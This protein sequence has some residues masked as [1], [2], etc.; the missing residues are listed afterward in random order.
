MDKE[1]VETNW[2]TLEDM[3]HKTTDVIQQYVESPSIVTKGLLDSCL[4]H[5]KIF[6][7][8]IEENE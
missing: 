1:S 3:L 8:K 4:K 2:L 5:N 7:K 6:L